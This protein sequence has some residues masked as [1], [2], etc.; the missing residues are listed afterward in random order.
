MS[1]SRNGQ[2]FTLG[3][4]GDEP[5][6]H[7]QGSMGLGLAPVAV[8][9][10]EHLS[11]DGSTVRGVRYGAR[12]VFLPLLVEAG[13]TA[14]LTAI[15]RD[16]M[17]LLAPHLGPV[18]IRIVDPSTG[19]DRLI[20]GYYT[21][22]LS[23]EFGAD[24][25][26][27]WQT[28]GLTFDCPDPWWLGDEHTTTFRVNPGVK[29]F[30]SNTVP[31]FPMV[32][33]QST[34]IGRFEVDIAGDGEAYPVWEVTGPGEDLI[35]SDGVSEVRIDGMFKPGEVVRIDTRDG[36]ITPDRWADV[37]V[38]SRLFALQ[39]G[40]SVLTVTMVGASEDTTVLLSY[41]ERFLE[42]I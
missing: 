18:D 34:V 5:V 29:P 33:A 7:I 4:S 2:V 32:L 6:L 42:A 41:R 35:I 25:H 15:R 28:L 11:G 39:P 26:G 14:E 24:F 9:S 37:P 16:L 38:D 13:S 10:S 19:T 27:S 30:L 40:R 8:A 22:G 12:E 36:R 21:S 3:R 20:R 17:R 31:F 23:G 1:L